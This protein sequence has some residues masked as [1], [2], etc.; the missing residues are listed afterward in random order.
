MNGLDQF[1]HLHKPALKLSVFSEDRVEPG[2]D[3]AGVEWFVGLTRYL[4]HHCFP[5]VVA[6][7]H[8]QITRTTVALPDKRAQLGGHYH[9]KR[10]VTPLCEDIVVDL[11][12]I[13]DRVGN[14]R[15]RDSRKM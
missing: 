13:D 1:H 11:R 7:V 4:Y 9:V 2:C 15:N 10:A 5:K 12:V 3:A 8:H 14:A 6:F